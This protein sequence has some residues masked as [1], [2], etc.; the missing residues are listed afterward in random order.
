MIFTFEQVPKA[1]IKKSLILALILA[2]TSGCAA[3]QGRQVWRVRDI[4]LAQ[5]PTIRLLGRNEQVVLTLN[6]NTVQQ[7]MLAHIRISRTAGIPSE[8]LFVEGDEPNAFAALMNGRRVIGLNTAMIK[9]IGNDID[10]FAA[11]L[12]HEAAHWARGH[13]EKGQIRSNTI[14]GLGSLVGAGLGMAGVPAAGTISGLGADLIE[15]AYSRD[16]ERE[17][18]ASSVEYMIANGYDPEAAVRLQ[19]KFLTLPGKGSFSFLSS[20]PSGA[21]RIKNLRAVIQ[22]KRS[23]TEAK[24]E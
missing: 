21:E 17:A 20:H 1:R 15:A 10:E 5:G 24:Q 6:R 4:A 23:Q 11:L 18:D 2:V 7:L 14:R 3:L 9:L 19:E 12:G 8:L 13:V 16:D 22:A